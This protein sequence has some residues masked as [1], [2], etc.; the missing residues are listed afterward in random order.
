MHLDRASSTLYRNVRGH[1]GFTIGRLARNAM[2]PD[3][4]CIACEVID[5]NQPGQMML[6]M[7]SRKS[8]RY[9]RAYHAKPL[10]V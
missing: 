5:T 9:S 4:G 8:C 7:I 2:P 10:G 3:S 1:G 6:G